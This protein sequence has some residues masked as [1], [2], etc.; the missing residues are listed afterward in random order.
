VYDQNAKRWKYEANRLFGKVLLS[1]YNSRDF[2][3][4]WSVVHGCPRQVMPNGGCASS[5]AAP[6]LNSTSHALALNKTS[7][8]PELWKHLCAEINPFQPWFLVKDPVCGRILDVKATFAPT[9]CYVLVWKVLLG[10][11]SIFTVFY[12]MFLETPYFYFAY[13]TTWALLCCTFYS[14]LSILNTIMAA[15]TIQPTADEAVSCR[16]RWTWVLL[17]A[18]LHSATAASLLVWSGAPLDPHFVLNYSMFASH[19]IIVLLT[20]VDG[21]YVN[22]I[23]LRWMHYVGCALPMDLTYAAWSCIHAAL[24]IGNPDLGDD[25]PDTNDDAI[26]TNVLEWD[27]NWPTTLAL[28][29]ICILIVGPMVFAALW[30]LSLGACSRSDRTRYIESVGPINEEPVPPTEPVVPVEP[31]MQDLEKG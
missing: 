6:T 23:P 5:A 28:T 16:F 25:D 10:A 30:A 15:R 1:Y 26:Y 29:C 13:F 2:V 21:L 9:S 20:L 4:G 3:M 12:S 31:A 11:L 7:I 27:S 18:G 24:Q 17:A 22:R 19:G 8:K 14:L